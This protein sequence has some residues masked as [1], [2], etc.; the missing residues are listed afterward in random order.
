MRQDFEKL[1]SHF[2]SAEPPVGLFDRII[3]AIKREQKLQH[4]RKLL[5][6]FFSLLIV[7]FVTIPLSW[8]LLVQQINSSGIS[9][10]VSTAFNNLSIFSILWQDFSLAILESLPV[11]GIIAFTISTGIA[12]FTLRLFL[13]RKRLLLDYLIHNVI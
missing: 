12:L 4:T 1:F 2:E 9:Y 3:F 8:S 13:Y 5:F 11:I 10:F 6:G 7:S